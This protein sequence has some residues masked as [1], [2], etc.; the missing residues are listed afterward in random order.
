MMMGSCHIWFGRYLCFLDLAMEYAACLYLFCVLVRWFRFV[1]R[2][3]CVCS[4]FST[5]ICYNIF[6]SLLFSLGY[7]TLDL[8][9]CK[10]TSPSADNYN[11]PG[12]PQG[13]PQGQPQTTTTRGAL[14]GGVLG[15]GAW[16]FGAFGGGLTLSS[17][18][19]PV[20]SSISHTPF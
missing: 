13:R 11:G 4:S 3:F 10:G 9:I 14:G 1:T 18:A 16:T 6:H 15:Y 2:S 20:A 8:S 5:N 17:T 7:I 19:S 12:Q